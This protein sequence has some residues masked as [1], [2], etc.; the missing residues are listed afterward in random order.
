MWYPFPVFFIPVLIQIFIL[1]HGPQNVFTISCNTD[2]LAMN[3]FSSYVWKSLYF[4]FGFK[5]NRIISWQSFFIKGVSP[6]FSGLFVLQWEICCLSYFVPFFFPTVFFQDFIFITGLKQFDYNV[7]WYSFY[8]F[9]IFCTCGLWNVLELWV[10]SLI[11][12]WKIF[13]SSFFK[14]ILST[15]LPLL[16]TQIVCIHGH[17]KLSQSSMFHSMGMEVSSGLELG[18]SRP[19]GQVGSTQTHMFRLCERVLPWG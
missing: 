2:L 16:G 4:A 12:A 7:S 5:Q 3:S 11:H 19:S 9:H 1:Y 8:F 17:L 10:Y 13:S 6:L 15:P 14:K 18:I